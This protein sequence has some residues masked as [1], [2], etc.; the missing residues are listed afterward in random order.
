MNREIICVTI[1]LLKQNI[2][3]QILIKSST[4]ICSWQQKNRFPSPS[5]QSFCVNDHDNTRSMWIMYQYRFTL[6]LYIHERMMI[7]SGLV[8]CRANHYSKSASDTR[9][10]QLNPFKITQKLDILHTLR[11]VRS[12]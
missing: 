4:R 8:Q 6:A 12:Q 5:T 11:Y 2:G 1:T 3:N 9:A 10:C 7:R